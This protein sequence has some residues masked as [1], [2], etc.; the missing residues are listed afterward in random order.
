[1]SELLAIANCG[2]GSI[3]SHKPVPQRQ[4]LTQTPSPTGAL[5][6][7]R[8]VSIASCTYLS[9]VLT[10]DSLLKFVSSPGGIPA[11]LYF[12]IPFILVFLLAAVGVWKKPKA[13]L[14]TAVATSGVSLILIGPN[15]S[16]GERLS[17]EGLLAGGAIVNGVLFVTLFF[18]LFGARASFAKAPP[19][20]GASFR[21]GR[22]TGIG[23]TIFLLIFTA[24]G[25]AYGSTQT[26]GIANTGQADVVIAPGAGYITSSQFYVPQTL[27]VKA[28]QAVT[29]KNLDN[30]PHTIT[31]ETGLFASGNIDVGG[32]YSYTFTH[33]GTYYYT[34][35]YHSWMTGSIVVV[36]G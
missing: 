9:A 30:T 15:L 12:S 14:I 33:P 5:S 22:K 20:A 11:V 7:E 21:P 29:W 2:Q 31:S 18:S 1:M 36:S 19:S 17:V 6:L 34:C 8:K 10:Y 35:D 4:G 24:L 28:G 16:L 3:Y 32:V 25:V 26:I 13:G 27:Q 23:A